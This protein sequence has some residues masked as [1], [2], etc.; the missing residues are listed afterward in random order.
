MLTLDTAPVRKPIPVMTIS[1]PMA[2]STLARCPFIRENS[3]E[4][5]STMKAA[6][7]N[8]IPS[9]AEYTASRPAP[10]VTVAWRG[11]FGRARLWHIC[12]DGLSGREEFDRGNWCFS[13]FESYYVLCT[14]WKN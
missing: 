1:T 11:E 4:N 9:P 13:P 10:F 7:R 12:V 8:G 5:C 2:C 14:L 3:D 6:I